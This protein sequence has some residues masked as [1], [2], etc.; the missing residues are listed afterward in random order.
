MKQWPRR[1]QW[2]HIH[3]S[4]PSFAQ[5]IPPLLPLLI[6][7]INSLLKAPFIILNPFIILDSTR[8]NVSQTFCHSLLSQLNCLFLTV[9]LDSGRF[10]LSR[11]MGFLRPHHLGTS[12]PSNIFMSPLTP[13]SRPYPSFCCE[14]RSF[15]NALSTLCLLSSLLS[16]K[17]TL[18]PCPSNPS[19]WKASRPAPSPSGFLW[20]N[21]ITHRQCSWICRH[22]CLEKHRFPTLLNF[23]LLYKTSASSCLT[24]CFCPFDS[25]LPLLLSS[26]WRPCWTS[27]CPSHT[28]SSR[29]AG[30]LSSHLFLE[31]CS[32]FTTSLT[33][34]WAAQSV[35]KLFVIYSG[36]PHPAN[37]LRPK[38]A[39]SCLMPLVELPCIATELF[40]C[41]HVMSTV[42]LLQFESRDG[43][44]NLLKLPKGMKWSQV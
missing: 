9:L 29:N 32:H 18:L 28:I 37:L 1:A 43:I 6:W 26:P 20:M 8:L 7:G 31:I 19:A 21:L 15:L 14:T 34:F 2:H 17:D 12:T 39:L 35:S 16:W 40:M 36:H 41:V 38:H 25:A 42:T 11:S 27:P 22:E 13:A 23:S 4:S 10:P 5:T 44:L 33:T 30:A 3:L 24:S